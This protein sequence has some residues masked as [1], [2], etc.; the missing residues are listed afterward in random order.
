M[1]DSS[2]TGRHS[3]R[4]PASNRFAGITR[5]V[6]GAFQ[7]EDGSIIW[8]FKKL[9]EM[10]LVAADAISE[11]L[12]SF[13]RSREVQH[14]MQDDEQQISVQELNERVRA[15]RTQNDMATRDTE[16]NE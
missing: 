8:G 1:S 4:R 6:K 16:V 2:N 14:D 12:S 10:V 7:G 3:A 15:R 5:T 13:T 9:V 11:Q